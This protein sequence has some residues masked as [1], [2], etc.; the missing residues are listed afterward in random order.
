MS[1]E[2]Q[3][4]DFS[5][6]H[7]VGQSVPCQGDTQILDIVSKINSINPTDPI[8]NSPVMQALRTHE[9]SWLKNPE[10][11]NKY[12]HICSKL[13]NFTDIQAQLRKAILASRQGTQ[14]KQIDSITHAYDAIGNA[15][16]SGTIGDYRQNIQSAIQAAKDF[17]DSYS[18][19]DSDQEDYL[20]NQLT[21]LD[22]DAAKSNEDQLS[23]LQEKA[24][25]TQLSLCRDVTSI[26]ENLSKLLLKFE[27]I[28]ARNE[29][30]SK[31]YA[32][33]SK[34]IAIIAIIISGLGIFASA[35][36]QWHFACRAEEKD[37]MGKL[38]EVVEK[39]HTWGKQPIP[40]ENVKN[41]NIAFHAIINAMNENIQNKNEIVQLHAGLRE[42][43]ARL[44]NIQKRYE[45]LTESS[46]QERQKLQLIIA[47][48]KKQIDQQKAELMKKTNPAPTTGV[49]KE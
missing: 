35:I 39:A 4:N 6:T 38:I 32:C 24:V 26:S 17:S 48:L 40:V 25:L 10:W 29:T 16:I 2:Q 20:V 44:V 42:T 18:L 23:D 43:Q 5:K 30:A 49:K 12:S 31:K 47:D 46:R 11:L 21:E 13:P 27:D 1:D 15:S 33:Q 22:S 36:I 45:D 9:E 7:K 14:K 41:I 3:V 8:F 37:K 28:A 19:H 34:I